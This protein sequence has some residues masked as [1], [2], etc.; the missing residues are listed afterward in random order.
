VRQRSPRAKIEAHL[1]FIRALPCICCGNNIETQ[2]AHIRM[3]DARV[4]K[5]N[6]GVGAKADDYWTLPMCGTHHDEQHRTG[7]ERKFWQRY[8]IDPILY[9]LRL[10]SVTGNHELGCEVVAAA[11]ANRPNIL[12][13]G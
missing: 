6:A 11:T 10:W 3:S 12:M 9:A 13:A 2:A 4:V 5:V 7:N 1:D 8:G